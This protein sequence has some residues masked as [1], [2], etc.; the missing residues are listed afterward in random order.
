MFDKGQGV[1]QNRPLAAVWLRRAAARG[2]D[3]AA[4]YLKLCG[5]SNPRLTSTNGPTFKIFRNDGKKFELTGPEF[6][7]FM[8][9]KQFGSVRMKP[10]DNRKGG[11]R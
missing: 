7:A 3:K 2:L 6:K 1:P 4:G 8:K 11:V 5:D 9:D 10:R